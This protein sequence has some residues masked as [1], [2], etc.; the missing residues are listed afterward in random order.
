MVR[1]RIFSSEV[2][3]QYIG[4]YI[5]YGI[6][7]LLPDGTNAGR[8]EDISENKDYVELIRDTLN[9][10]FAEAVHLNEIIEDILN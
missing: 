8:I 9:N 1:Y 10:G 5:G 6:E 3:S 4:M 2:Y 7:A